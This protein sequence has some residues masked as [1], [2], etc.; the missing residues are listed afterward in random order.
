MLQMLQLPY[1]HIF[2][3]S[4]Y[5]AFRNILMA[6]FCSVSKSHMPFLVVNYSLNFHLCLLHFHSEEEMMEEEWKHF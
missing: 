6:I 5:C 2:S 3:R 4:L 1:Q